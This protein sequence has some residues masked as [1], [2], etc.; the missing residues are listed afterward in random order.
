MGPSHGKKQDA[1]DSIISLVEHVATCVSAALFNSFVLVGRVR[2]Y[3]FFSPPP[4]LNLSD[5]PLS[6]A[7]IVLPPAL[8]WACFMWPTIAIPP[9]LTWLLWSFSRVEYGEGSPWP[10]YSKRF[11]MFPIMRHFFSLKI[12]VHDALV[13]HAQA[14]ANGQQSPPQYFIGLHPHGPTCD[15]RVYMDGL[16][17]QELPFLSSWRVLSASVLFRLPY[18]RELCLW[19]H[20]IDASRGSA[21]KAL[22]AGHTI[23]VT[24]GGEKEQI[25]CQRG[26]EEVYITKRKGFVR[27]ALKHGTPL[28]PCYVFGC[29]DAYTTS[30][31]LYSLRLWLV[32]RFSI[33]IP[34]VFGG[35]F[36]IPCWPHQVQLNVC[37]G[38]PI[39]LG[40]C[41]VPEE[42]SREEVNAA[43]DK[44]L[45]GLKQLFDENKEKYGYA[46]RELIIS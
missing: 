39:V 34:F 25:L 15:W 22:K 41:Q 17:D 28:V 26:V 42:P 14:P 19:T 10:L 29:T 1:G 30:R 18:I 6:G 12:S 16:V 40:K 27:L 3:P 21:E 31:F 46:N 35:P 33:A 32:K 5:Y 23:F 20:C 37:F 36:L 13:K 7:F 43:H 44:Y 8:I 4:P 38:E 45:R 2:T 9:C 11:P 24:P